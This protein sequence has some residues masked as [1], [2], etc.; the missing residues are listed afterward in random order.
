MFCIKC[1]KEIKD[2]SR[3]CPHCGA[4]I[5]GSAPSSTPTQLLQTAAAKAYPAAKSGMNWLSSNSAVVVPL[6]KAAAFVIMIFLWF[7]KL[8]TLS[9]MGSTQK[10]SMLD[11]SKG[12]EWL[13]Y[14]TAVILAIGAVCSIFQGISRKLNIPMLASGWTAFWFIGGILTASKQLG[15]YSRYEP[16]FTLTFAGWL[17]GILSVG[18][19]V[20]TLLE[21]KKRK[22]RVHTFQKTEK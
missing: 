14:L 22:R 1:G 17:L 19:L 15:E 13:S 11:M 7:S 2:G 8:V 12:A 10:F 16:E 3:I 6:A 4:P 21:T 18:I 9:V 20:L 5:K